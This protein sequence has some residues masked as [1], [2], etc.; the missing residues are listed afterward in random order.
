MVN[1]N[2][3]VKMI[4]WKQ[5]ENKIK[6]KTKLTKFNKK[7]NKTKKTKCNKQKLKLN[8]SHMSALG[9]SAIVRPT[10]TYLIN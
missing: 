7:K 5:S 8:K 3:K 1:K 6:R 2:Q 9:H 4:K 10:Q